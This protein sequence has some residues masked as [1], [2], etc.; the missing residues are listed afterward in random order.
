MGAEL[1]VI[2]GK[3]VVLATLLLTA[4][5]VMV[6]VERR[7]AAF[8]QD[9]LGPNRVGPWGIIQPIADSVK[10]LFKEDLTPAGVNRWL[11]FL[12]PM[13]SVFIAM[14]TFIVVPFGDGSGVTLLD[15]PLGSLMVASELEVGV[16]YLL[17]ISSLGVYGIVLAGWSSNNKYSLLGGLRASAQLISYELS[18]GLAVL[19]VILATGSLR[20]DEVVA[21]QSG[22]VWNA[23]PQLIGFVVFVIAAFAETNRLPF[24]LA[25]AETE[26]VAGYHV[27]YSS[28][29]FAAFMMSEYVN[30]VTASALIVTLFL[31]GWTLPGVHLEGWLG[32]GVSLA[33][34]L[35]KV[36]FFMWLFVWVR[37]SLPR[38]RYDQLMRLGWKG[39]LPLATVNLV[40]VAVGV[41]LGWKWI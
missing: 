6:W 37:W 28:M 31:G 16:L 35:G 12:A 21:A 38:F 15:Q 7:G 17:A 1:I 36:A 22:K 40:W 4:V 13:I 41:A 19:G 25:E 11:Y 14:L 23:V 24:D 2:A 10:L 34:F 20:L 39:L 27:E 29:K 8:I 3:L 30:M 33:V 5:P 18:M 32:L 9:R 26:L